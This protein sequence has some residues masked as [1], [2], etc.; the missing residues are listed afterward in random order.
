MDMLL[1][2]LVIRVQGSPTD[3]GLK[4]IERPIRCQIVLRK[5]DPIHERD[6]HYRAVP[7]APIVFGKTSASSRSQILPGIVG[8]PGQRNYGLTR[9]TQDRLAQV[10][11]INTGPMQYAFFLQKDRQGV[12]IISAGTFGHPDLNRRIR[13]E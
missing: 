13:P 4:L 1:E 8:N 11:G 10:R 12:H 6:A 2:P 3:N 5:H 9:V 7:F